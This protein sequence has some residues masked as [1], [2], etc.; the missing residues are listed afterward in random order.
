M[1]QHV[2]RVG[3]YYMSRI[4]VEFTAT[5]NDLVANRY[6]CLKLIEV[7]QQANANMLTFIDN[8]YWTTAKALR[9]F[10]WHD[11]IHARAL[12]RFAVRTWGYECVCDPFCFG[13]KS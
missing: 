2:D 3:A 5:E 7:N 4:N 6:L 8:E 10:I 1:L 13:N 11:R 12:Y 9:R